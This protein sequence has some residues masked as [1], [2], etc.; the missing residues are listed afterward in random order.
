M[1]VKVNEGFWVLITICLFA[2]C[3]FSYL[4]IKGN[5]WYGTGIIFLAFLGIIALIYNHKHD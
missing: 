5:F 1:P 2:I 4:G 3:L